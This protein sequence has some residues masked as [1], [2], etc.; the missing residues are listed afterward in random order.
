LKLFLILDLRFDSCWIWGSDRPQLCLWTFISAA[1]ISKYLQMFRWRSI[2]IP[3]RHSKYA[4]L[5][6]LR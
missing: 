2:I 6:G 4:V 3:S 1:S 5:S